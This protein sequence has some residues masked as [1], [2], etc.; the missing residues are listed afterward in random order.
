MKYGTNNTHKTFT[1]VLLFISLLSLSASYV[2]AQSAASSKPDPSTRRKP[3][4]HFEKEADSIQS[5]IFRSVGGG[6]SLAIAEMPFETREYASDVGKSKGIDAGKLYLWKF[7][8]TI[9]TAF[10]SPPF[11]K[12]GNAEPTVFTD[13]ESAT[14]KGIIS[15]H[16]KLIS[17]KRIKFGDNE[18]TE[19]HYES[20]EGIK[21]IGRI[22]LIG[23]VGYQIVGA[24]AGDLGENEVVKTLDSF[25]LLKQ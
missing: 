20:A 18:G 24:Y 7:D 9:Y 16:G 19:F 12:D 21:F 14:R 23:S 5:G 4:L 1:K 3:M 11:D 13:M 10:Y 17:E 25:K 8:K 6:F 22:F 2:M 15:G